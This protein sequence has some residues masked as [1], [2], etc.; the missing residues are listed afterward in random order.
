M[1]G[2]GLLSLMRPALFR[3]AYCQGAAQQQ[4]KK[5]FIIAFLATQLRDYPLRA[6]FSHYLERASMKK[7]SA[8][9]VILLTITA[10]ILLNTRVGSIPPLAKFLDPMQGV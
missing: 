9:F 7:K 2:R 5:F 6:L 4:L 10:T 8:F 1:R 3:W